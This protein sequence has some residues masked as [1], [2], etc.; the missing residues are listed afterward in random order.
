MILV[1]AMRTKTNI[2]RKG[3][4]TLD[5]LLLLLLDRLLNHLVH[6]LYQESDKLKKNDV[7]MCELRSKTISSSSSIFNL[8]P[9]SRYLRRIQE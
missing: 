9:E 2:W 6:H 4:M 3:G 5:F 1:A 7:Q 8:P